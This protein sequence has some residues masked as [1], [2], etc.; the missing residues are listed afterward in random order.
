MFV[1]QTFASTVARLSV[2]YCIKLLLLLVPFGRFLGQDTRSTFSKL[3]FV[4][5]QTDTTPSL[6]HCFKSFYGF[7]GLFNGHTP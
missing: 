2:A 4:K 6:R 3:E 1:I 7:G 5:R